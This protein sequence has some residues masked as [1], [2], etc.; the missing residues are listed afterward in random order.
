VSILAK[1][2]RRPA[3]RVLRLVIVA[4]SL[5]FWL[6]GGARPARAHDMSPGSTAVPAETAAHD[7]PIFWRFDFGPKRDALIAVGVFGGVAAVLFLRRV[8]GRW[9]RGGD[10]PDVRGVGGPRR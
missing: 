8:G 6:M 4:V 1:S 9:S 10:R 7:E 2:R 5:S 3:L